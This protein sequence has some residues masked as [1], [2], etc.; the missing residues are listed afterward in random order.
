MLEVCALSQVIASMAP[1]I[2]GHED[3]KRA[4]ALA[5]FGGEPKDPGKHKW[6]NVVLLLIGCRWTL[7][8]GV[9]LLHLRS[10]TQS[11]RRY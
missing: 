3:V 10:K 5:L 9:N 8:I 4:L 7:I 1:S 2:Y 6:Y 11:A